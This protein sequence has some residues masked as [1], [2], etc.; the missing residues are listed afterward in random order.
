MVTT[1]IRVQGLNELVAG[2]QIMPE[3][4][5]AENEKAMVIAEHIAEAE[6]KSLT[7]RRTGRLFSAWQ[8]ATRGAGFTA[9]GI[10]ADSVS[11]APYVEAGVG[12]HDIVARGNALMIPV[13]ESGF[14][15]G[16]L[17]GGARSGQQVAFYKK[18]RH[19]GFAG[20]HMAAKGLEIAR[21]AIVAEFK[22]AAERAAKL[23]FSRATSLFRGALGV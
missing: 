15:G 18:V 11:Y 1:V 12:P 14:G 21:P 3:V 23:V 8:T 7:P 5:A 6:I 20:R 9:V 17:S 19:P 2:F 16:T 10:V 13:G 22:A 4:M